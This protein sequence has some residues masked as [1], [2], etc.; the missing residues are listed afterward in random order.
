MGLC[1]GCGRPR[2]GHP[3]RCGKNCAIV[4][5]ERAKLGME[6]V[7]MEKPENGH[8]DGESDNG[9]NVSESSHS[10]SNIALS[11]MARVLADLSLSVQ[12][13]ADDQ[14]E[15][16][17]KVDELP[18]GRTAGAGAQVPINRELN[19]AIPPTLPT[20]PDINQPELVSLPTGARVPQKNY[21]S[22]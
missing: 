2:K 16:C 14:K 8:V 6:T 4:K 9:S 12:K 19:N 17:K 13:I 21:T 11:H 20:F 7:E 1:R 15:L 5:A 10:T 22:C 3:G 18:S